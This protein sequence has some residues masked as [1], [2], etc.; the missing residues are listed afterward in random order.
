[1][2]A[3]H[4]IVRKT[5]GTIAVASSAGGVHAINPARWKVAIYIYG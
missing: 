2:T 3:T 5:S 1:M 4:T